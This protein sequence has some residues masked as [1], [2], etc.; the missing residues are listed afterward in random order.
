VTRRPRVALL[1]A[2][3][4][5]GCSALVTDTVLQGRIAV[6]VKTRQ[7]TPLS[8]VRL[9]LF[10]GDRQLEYARTD[11]LGRVVFEEVPR[12]TYGVLAELKEPVRGLGALGAGGGEGNVKLPINIVGG[13]EAPVAITLLK[14]GTGTFE[15]VVRDNDSLPVGNVEITA[16]TPTGFIGTKRS[17]AAGIARFDSIPFGPFGAFAI[18]PDSIGGPDVAPIDRQGMFFDAGHFERRTYT[19]TR[20][21][22]TITAQVLDQANAP[23]AN[24]SVALYTASAFE[25]RL[26]T[27]VTG[28]ATFTLVRCG[29]YYVTAEPAAGFTVNY[30]RGQ[31]FQDGLGVTLGASLTPTL[32]VT[33]QP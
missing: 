29:E 26:T 6:E 20:C 12:G 30:V 11:S 16:Y 2:L 19:I 27:G 7:G 9:T 24:Y 32:R 23:V 13:D 21:R 33:R 22:G 1:A 18:V 25:R 28:L 10:R 5:A 3:L 15:A 17:D 4:A 14:V 8:D 31:G